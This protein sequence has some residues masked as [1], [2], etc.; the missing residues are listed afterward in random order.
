LYAE[1]RTKEL[2]TSTKEQ[3]TLR[4]ADIF[5]GLGG[6]HLALKELGHKCV[7]ACELDDSLRELYTTNFNL[8]PASDIR[9]VPL[10]LIPAHDVLCAG[11]PCQPFSKA[12][13]QSGFECPTWGDL[14]DHIVSILK[15]HQPEFVLLENVP[16][17]MKHNEGRTW[18]RVARSLRKIGYEC[19]A[20]ILSPHQ[21]GVPQIRERVYIVARLRGLQQFAWP[22]GQLSPE[23]SVETVLDTKPRDARALSQQVVDCL[24]MWQCFIDRFPKGEELPTFPIWAMEFGANYPYEDF[25]PS[26]IRRSELRKFRGTF[27]L[28]LAKVAKGKLIS[29]L[30][31]YAR[32]DEKRFPDWK[33]D[34]I[35]KNRELYR[36]NKKWID[37][38]KEELLQFPPSLQKLEWNCKGGERDIWKYV[39]QFRA[40]GVRVKKPSTAPSLIAM[41][42]TQV[43]IIAWERRYMTPRECAKLQSMECLKELPVA[44]TA[45]Y[46]ALGNAINVH[47]M[48]CVARSLLNAS[49]NE[50][51]AHDGKPTITISG[52]RIRDEIQV[53]TY[54]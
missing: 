26:S 17:L 20:R 1:Q 47:V 22:E 38:W 28:P 46:K 4:F 52:R 11:F 48:K 19:D 40:S 7:F 51:S 8:T 43:P 18:A 5:S 6:F 45:A 30:P 42:V 12:G 32:T 15:H 10:T 34:F 25:T 23:L 13:E 2:K 33:I 14:F 24:K 21:F 29:A 31:P 44:S 54:S 53:A 35:R 41:T 37:G 49:A 3:R 39:I 16:N 9:K 36:R 50:S 27:G